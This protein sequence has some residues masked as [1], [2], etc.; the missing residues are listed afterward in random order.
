MLN[1]CC[2]LQVKGYL[3]LS[4]KALT[5]KDLHFIPTRNSQRL[6]KFEVAKNFSI[7]I[8]KIARNE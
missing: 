6:E 5:K 1:T 4:K 8:S 7:P 3:I 2:T